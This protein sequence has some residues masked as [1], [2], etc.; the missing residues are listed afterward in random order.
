M[1]NT[2]YSSQQQ[3]VTDSF[4]LLHDLLQ[5]R[6]LTPEDASC[7][8][9]L[10]T[11]LSK[12]GF[13]RIHANSNQ[14]T[15]SLYL[16][17]NQAAQNTPEYHYFNATLQQSLAKQGYLDLQDL[18]QN[19]IV[20]T[21]FCFLGHTDVVPV[22]DEQ[23]WLYEAFAGVVTDADT[24]II[25]QP[26]STLA[27]LINSLQTSEEQ[28]A[29]QPEYYHW[30]LH[31][32]GAT[33][34]KAGLVSC[35][36]AAQQFVSHSQQHNSTKPWVIGLL[37]TSDEEGI[38]IDGTKYVVD[39]L[40]KLGSSFNYAIVGEP[41]SSQALGDTIRGGRRGSITFYLQVHGIQGHVAYPHLVDNP[42]HKASALINSLAQLQLD[43]GNEQFPP[44][45]LQIVDIHAGDG[46]TN[47]VP[48]HITITFNIR[49]NN[50]HTP[51]SLEQLI[52]QL[53][54]QHLPDP[55]SFTLTSSC[56]GASFL[57]N[58]QGNLLPAVTQAIIATTGY[59]QEHALTVTSD[60]ELIKQLIR[61]DTGGGTS[62]G[63]FMARICPET[64]EF[65]T[66]NATLHKVNEKVRFGE[67]I[68]LVAVYQQVLA[69]LLNDA[70]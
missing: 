10:E 39:Y 69:T 42:I 55:N 66:T 40:E 52:T 1:T 48:A 18:K 37:V 67:V 19:F 32:R 26:T 9:Q 5:R 46:T 11:Y 29:E 56:S 51:A 33:D 4:A 59:A 12:A 45:S 27:N 35:A 2:S 36:V 41:S 17:Y 57:S 50:F 14:V 49:F 22:G 20:D 21:S 6:S 28:L 43:A 31:G 38:A 63:R 62:D 15:N 25:S 8:D 60:A 68:E 54:T 13:I 58:P 65:G 3:V 44:S 24:R 7:Q 34:M 16:Y 64:L 47:L 53:V 23:Q 61:V 30:T 70:K